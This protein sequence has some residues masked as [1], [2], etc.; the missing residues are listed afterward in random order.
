[1]ALANATR[2]RVTGAA[3]VLPAPLDEVMRLTYKLIDVVVEAVV[4][5]VD[6]R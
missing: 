6:V 3:D 5:A 4:Y 2:A 1:L